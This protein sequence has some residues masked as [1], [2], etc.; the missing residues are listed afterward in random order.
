[1]TANSSGPYRAAE[2]PQDSL[3]VTVIDLLREIEQLEHHPCP[4][5]FPG[6]QRGL[7][8]EMDFLRNRIGEIMKSTA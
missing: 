2:M 8:F 3:P 6:G 1:M 5:N 4:A 7:E